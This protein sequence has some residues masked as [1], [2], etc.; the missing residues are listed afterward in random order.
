MKKILLGTAAVLLLGAGVANATDMPTTP[1]P[2]YQAPAPFYDWSGLYVGLYAGV[3]A[4]QTRG[5]DPTGAI[6]GTV[7][8]VGSAFT[9]GL[10]AGY[11][12]QIDRTWLIGVEADFGYLGF[13]HL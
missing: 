1:P 11:N 2:V 13:D 4:Q 12:W 6:A 3:G 5:F 10:T 8:H 7:E 9:G